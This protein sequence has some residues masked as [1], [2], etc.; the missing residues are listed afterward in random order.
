MQTDQIISDKEYHISL[1]NGLKNYLLL[2]ADE[3]DIRN[4]FADALEFALSLAR[5]D[6]VPKEKPV[7]KYIEALTCLYVL[8]DR[9]NP[10]RKSSRL[11][12]FFSHEDY[13]VMTARKSPTTVTR[14][15]R[16]I[17]KPSWAL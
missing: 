5:G 11:M 3:S 7:D 9:M 10:S 2:K 12:E 17:S 13:T 14:C 6:A 15:P 1:L 4:L 16:A 8:C